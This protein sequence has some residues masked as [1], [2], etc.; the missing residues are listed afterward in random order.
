MDQK[1]YE[2]LA[3]LETQIENLTTLVIELKTQISSFT[4]NF[5]TRLEV[6]EMFRSR[7][8]DIQETREELK[9]LKNDKR[10]SA[11]QVASWAGIGVAILALFVSYF[12]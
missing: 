4:Q 6:N 12:K 8:Q 11:A 10:A 9:E 2:R 3:K 1:D 5:P 7:D